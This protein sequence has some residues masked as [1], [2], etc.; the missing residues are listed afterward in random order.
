MKYTEADFPFHAK[1][2]DELEKDILSG[3]YKPGDLIPS[4]NELADKKGISRP[5]VRQAFSE[6]VSKGLLN[7]VKGKGTFVSDFKSIQIFDHTK[8]FIHTILDCNDNEF[9]VIKSVYQVDG[10]E[11]SGL[12]KLSEVFN[13]DS[14]Q[15]YSSRFIKVEY[16]YSNLN[17]YCESFL[18]LMYFPE[19]TVLLEKNARSHELL[20]GKIPLEPRSSKCTVRLST[21]GKKVAE[22]LE[23]SVGS[24]IL[25]LESTLINGRG[26]IVEYNIASYKPKNTE[27]IFTKIRNI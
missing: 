11:Y 27:I 3:K 8:G 7:K 2:R 24:E 10:N 1:L 21:A 12:R 23:L 25:T 16:T 9:R 22:T 20:S 6:L 4:E 18:P 15:G 19:A 26:A 14:S 5:T 13:L 17:I